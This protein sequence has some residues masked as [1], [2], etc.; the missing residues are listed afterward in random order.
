MTVL[1]LF[2][3]RNNGIAQFLWP[4]LQNYWRKGLVSHQSITYNLL[5]TQIDIDQSMLSR[6]A[7]LFGLIFW[8]DLRRIL[9]NFSRIF[10]EIMGNIELN[11]RR[12]KEFFDRIGFQV[13][14]RSEFTSHC[15]QQSLH[16]YPLLIWI[17]TTQNKGF[18]CQKHCYN[19][20]NQPSL[21]Q[22]VSLLLIDLDLII[23]W[24]P[25]KLKPIISN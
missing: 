7:T 14:E 24:Y 9:S 3:N 21:S 10:P 4:K 6:V 8:G 1:A 20:P 2:S 19:T 15:H 23:I 18:R 5:V 17:W 12:F 22:V 16:W 25:F 11:L 13:R